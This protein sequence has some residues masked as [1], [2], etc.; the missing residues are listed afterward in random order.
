MK[1]K[2]IG[3]AL[4]SEETFP[5]VTAGIVHQLQEYSRYTHSDFVGAV[6]GIGNARSDVGKDPR[7]PLAAARRFGQHFFSAH[8][9]DYKIDTPR[10]GRVWG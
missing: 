2:R 1:G 10:S 6:H 7:D 5:T 4:S 3:L 9:A 8:A